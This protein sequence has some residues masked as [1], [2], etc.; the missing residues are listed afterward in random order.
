[1]KIARYNK[2]DAEMA[3]DSLLFGVDDGCIVVYV[4]NMWYAPT[5]YN[6]QVVLPSIHPP[7]FTIINEPQE[8]KAVKIEG[9]FITI[10]NDGDRFYDY[11]G[12]TDKQLIIDGD[13]YFCE[14]MR[15]ET[16]RPIEIIKKGTPIILYCKKV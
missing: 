12:L 5:I 1:M 8:F 9:S 2:P 13:L 16:P 4:N 6:T 10:I 15:V 7:K 3:P 14:N 11:A